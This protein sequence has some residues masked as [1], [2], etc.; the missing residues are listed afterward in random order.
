MIQ[1]RFPIKIL[2]FF[3][4]YSPLFIILVLRYLAFDTIWFWVSLGIIFFSCYILYRIIKSRQNYNYT[5]ETV[6]KVKD[7]TGNS[8]NY[9]TGY[10]ISFFDFKFEQW[11]DFVSFCILIFIIS[12]IYL[13]SNLIY[14]NP[15]INLL[16]YRIYRIYLSNNR[17]YIVLSKDRKIIKDKKINLN[18]LTDN[19][20]ISQQE[21]VKK[22]NR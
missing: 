22:D 20:Y 9:I 5:Q 19:I 21:N 10:F 14:I 11:Q 18:N 12:Y 8:L 15:I 17:E 16:G 1:F 6:L 7:E 3:S 4:A 2:F 13:N